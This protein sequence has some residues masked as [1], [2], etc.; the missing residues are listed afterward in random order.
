MNKRPPALRPVVKEGSPLTSNRSGPKASACALVLLML[1]ANLAVLAVA[2]V[3]TVAQTSSSRSSSRATEPCPSSAA[4]WT[5]SGT[6]VYTGACTISGGTVQVSASADITFEKVTMSISGT[7]YFYNYA[8]LRILNSTISGSSNWYG[9]IGTT[10]NTLL[11][12]ENSTITGW[13]QYGLRPYT[14]C[15]F[16]IGNSTL[17]GQAGTANYGIYIYN[18]NSGF[19]THTI[20]RNATA[21]GLYV[22]LSSS[23]W[24]NNNTINS[25]SVSYGVYMN[26]FS[27]RFDNN[28]VSTTTGTNVMRLQSSAPSSF[29][30][31]R[32]KG[33]SIRLYQYG[34]TVN[35]YHCNFTGAS[36]TDVQIDNAGKLKAYDTYINTATTAAGAS[37]EVYWRANISVK[38]L[39]N[40]QAV[41]GALVD[42]TDARSYQSG[43]KIPTDAQGMIRNIYMMQFIK[44]TGGFKNASPYWI[45]A[46]FTKAGKDFFNHT[47][48]NMTNAT[49]NF[50][51]ILDDVPPPLF[52]TQPQDALITNDTWVIVKGLTEHNTSK[53]W[54]MKVDIH[55]GSTVY[56]PIVY[57]A[58]NFTQ[59]VS[60]SKEGKYSISVVAMDSDQNTKTKY[61]NI[62][63]DTVCPP[64]T[65]DRPADSTLT[66]L[67]TIEV[68][69]ATE[70][71]ATLTI[72]NVTVALQPSGVFTYQYKLSEGNNVIIVRSE[73][74]GH[75]WVQK[76]VN[77]KLDSKAPMLMVADPKDGSRTNQPKIRLQGT[78]EARALVTVN[79][80]PVL[81]SATSFMTNLDLVEGDNLINVQSCDIAGN[82]NS[83]VI[84]VFLDTAPPTLD[85]TTPKDDMLT[86]L[87]HVTVQGTV[88]EG[89]K[90][91][92]NGKPVTFVGSAFAY[93]VTLKEGKNMIVVKATD[94]VGNEATVSISVNVDTMPPLLSLNEPKDG[95]TI[96]KAEMIVSG[97]TETGAA[98]TVSGKK[99][100]N[101]NGGFSTKVTLVEGLNEIKVSATD[102]AGNIV[103]IS[104]KVTLDTKVAMTVK[105]ITQGT[106][107]QTTNQTYNLTGTAD[108]DASVFVNDLPV[109][110]HSDGTFRTEVPLELGTNYINVTAED[111]LGN[112][113][114]YSYQ[115]VR[116]SPPSPP[117]NPILGGGNGPL[118]G[119][120]VPL[121]IIV[122][123]VAAA[124]I[125]GGLYM[126]KR[127]KAAQ[128]SLAP[129]APQAV[130]PQPAA[131]PMQAPP[132]MYYQP[133]AMAQPQYTPPPPPPPPPP[134]VEVPVAPATPIISSEAMDLYTEAQRTLAEAEASGQ[135]VSRARTHLR[136]A[137]TFLNKGN[138]DKVILYSK[139]ALGRG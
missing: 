126:R 74:K 81:L 89:S 124:G 85:I 23:L 44:D 95:I 41:P 45:N 134:P 47:K 132:A 127:S 27:G 77:V 51:V 54:P 58:G 83:T 93:D 7:Y 71:G 101:T 111:P 125:G 40:D 82:C 109:I 33:G 129:V 86:N 135:D 119:M 110:V 97:T 117:P 9:I 32:L 133:P 115:V 17:V 90:V 11:K 34:Q 18:V 131:P 10:G 107:I 8:S 76:T 42:L 24:I 26:S 36:G 60:L 113:V 103:N 29:W 108:K 105:G 100:T 20:V 136:V 15:K 1:V 50:L 46:T 37:V 63:R 19:M 28:T 30:N 73:D 48:G 102:L 22:Y 67:S 65:L 39:S 14:G 116:K 98:V 35:A 139:K 38:W 75:N 137:Q 55:V 72:N 79:D 78:T 61:L 96:N 68:A 3:P 114:V 84:H 80:N 56:T 25:T 13:Y 70:P 64:L 130:A 16:E 94:D 121:V 49:N 4:G 2:A 12:V 112:R 91:T 87:G 59:N 43:T 66:N 104:V 53:E 138:S 122:A 123:V 52:V 57:A 6:H 128:A 62:T 31:N 106:A 69:G 120:L 88:E 118:G 21:Y 99:V 92:V 5:M